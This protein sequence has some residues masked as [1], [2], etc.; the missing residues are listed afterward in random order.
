MGIISNSMEEKKTWR[1]QEY[2]VGSHLWMNPTEACRRIGK[3]RNSSKKQ[4]QF[5]DLLIENTQ[6]KEWLI[7]NV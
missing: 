3:S 7:E 6:K 4:Q 1:L 2:R 5:F